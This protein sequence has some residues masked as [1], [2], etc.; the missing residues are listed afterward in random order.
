[1][2]KMYQENLK[3]MK[4]MNWVKKKTLK[5]V[6]HDDLPSLKCNGRHLA[7]ETTFVYPFPPGL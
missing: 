2:K 7:K 5:I 1:M 6:N 3:Y 4:M